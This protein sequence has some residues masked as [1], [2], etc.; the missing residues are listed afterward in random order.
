MIWKE[1]LPCTQ[2]STRKLST[3]LVCFVLSE[4]L[5]RIL[6]SATTGMNGTLSQTG[7]RRAAL[8]ADGGDGCRKPGEEVFQ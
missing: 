7:L 8:P 6:T 1:G 2:L 5:G 3:G 4:M